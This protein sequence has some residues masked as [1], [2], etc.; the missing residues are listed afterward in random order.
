VLCIADDSL[1]SHGATAWITREAIRAAIERGVQTFDFNGA[2]T[3]DRALDK[4]LYGT[5]TRLY[6]RFEIKQ[7]R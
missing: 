1:R 4:A 3:P 7:H 6:F 5:R 2:N